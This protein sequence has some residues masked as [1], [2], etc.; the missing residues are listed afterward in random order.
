MKIA[1]KDWQSNTFI[2][3]EPKILP[4]TLIVEY[5]NSRAMWHELVHW[6]TV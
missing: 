5:L 3:D 2:G 6:T 4:F 1:Q